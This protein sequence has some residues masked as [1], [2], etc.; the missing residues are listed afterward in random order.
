MKIETKCVATRETVGRGEG[1]TKRA[2]P[3]GYVRK[4]HRFKAGDFCEFCGKARR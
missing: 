4:R 1:N 2:R 3:A